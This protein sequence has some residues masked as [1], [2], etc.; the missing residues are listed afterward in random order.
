MDIVTK[1]DSILNESFKNKTL[2]F[3]KFIYNLPWDKQDA[4]EKSHSLGASG[5]EAYIEYAVTKFKKDKDLMDDAFIVFRED[6]N[7]AK[8]YLKS[9]DLPE[10]ILWGEISQ[11]EEIYDWLKIGYRKHIRW[12]IKK[13]EWEEIY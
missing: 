8:E 6:Y 2:E 13:R 3:G 12:N 11:L 9:L 5:M 1:I 7:K 10:N 4:I